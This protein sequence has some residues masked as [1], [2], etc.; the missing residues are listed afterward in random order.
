MQSISRKSSLKP[1]RVHPVAETVI[2]PMLET[3]TVAVIHQNPARILKALPLINDSMQR[4]IAEMSLN[5]DKFSI[6]SDE[7][8]VAD[9]KALQWHI[10]INLI[11]ILNCRRH[12]I[13]RFFRNWLN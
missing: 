7:T 8:T 3:V 9:S 11:R 4:C 6:K 13:D 12:A 1:S 5:K 10:F 2:R